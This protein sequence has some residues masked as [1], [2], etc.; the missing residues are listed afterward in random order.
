MLTAAIV[1]FA[2]AVAAEQNNNNDNN[3]NPVVAENV[4]K[5][6]AP[7]ER[8]LLLT[9]ARFILFRRLVIVTSWFVKRRISATRYL[10]AAKR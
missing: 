4:I 5:H 10:Q 1:V 8:I 7:P 3:P 6:N 9:G 2:L